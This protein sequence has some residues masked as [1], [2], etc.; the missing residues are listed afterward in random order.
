MK[1]LLLCFAIAQMLEFNWTLKFPE[2]ACFEET[3]PNNTLVSGYIYPYYN[4]SVEITLKAPNSSIIFNNFTNTKFKF[5]FPTL[6]A[7]PYSLCVHNRNRVKINLGVMFNV[8]VEAKNYNKYMP[9]PDLKA[10]DF[11][12]IKLEDVVSQLDGDFKHL[13]STS[14][15]LLVESKKTNGKV[16]IF[17][18]FSVLVLVIS[19]AFQILSVKRFLLFKKIA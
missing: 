4:Y 8:G 7:G 5:S 18:I 6:E 16:I 3:L 17:G 1:A 19:T 11:N 12:V 15:Q 13:H 2:K 14:T 9:K 10:F